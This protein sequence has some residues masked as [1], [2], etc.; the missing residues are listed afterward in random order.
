MISK[1]KLYEEITDLQNK[2]RSY[3]LMEEEYNNLCEEL[4]LIKSEERKYSWHIEI[5]IVNVEN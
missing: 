3:K 1:N 2:V 4:R 5:E